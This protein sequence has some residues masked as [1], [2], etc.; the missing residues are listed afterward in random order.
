MV[1]SGIRGCVLFAKENIMGGWI[2][3]LLLGILLGWL[4]FTL[5]KQTW[6]RWTAEG[7]M[8]LWKA[9]FTLVYLTSWILVTLVAIYYV[10]GVQ[11]PD[12]SPNPKELPT[13]PEGANLEVKDL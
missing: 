9:A 10:W 11:P 3:G 8:Q 13:C 4:V 1:V 12:I 2:I 7:R 5:W 6:P